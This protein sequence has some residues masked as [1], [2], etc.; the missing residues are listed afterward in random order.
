MRMRNTIDNSYSGTILGIK[1]GIFMTYQI[2]TKDELIKELSELKDKC[3][4]LKRAEEKL[5]LMQE[6]TQSISE[7]EDFNSALLIAIH[8][9]CKNR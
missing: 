1:V 7:S 3:E 6:I 8:K 9:I 2:K 5:R 4:E